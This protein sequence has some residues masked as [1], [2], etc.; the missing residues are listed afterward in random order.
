MHAANTGILIISNNDVKNIDQLNSSMKLNKYNNENDDTDNI[1]DI[2][3]MLPN[4]DDKPAICKLKNN[5]STDEQ[6]I[7]DK[8]T[9]KVQPALTPESISKL[10]IISIKEKNDNHNENKF[11]LG[12]IISLQP[13]SIGISKLPKPP[14]RTG[15]I[16]KNIISKP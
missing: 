9:Y 5:K 11:N 4:S 1:D 10:S 8:G 3:L 6:F 2:K 16:R 12:N 13:I 15:I 7:F 14:I